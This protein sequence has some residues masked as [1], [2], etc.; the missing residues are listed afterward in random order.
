MEE[1]HSQAS[2]I[3]FGKI[4]GVQARIAEAMDAA[5]RYLFSRQDPEE[6]HWCGELEADSTLESD[7]IVLHTLLG[8]G[9]AVKMEKATREILRHQNED[10][11]WSIFTDGPSNVSAT[12]KAYFSLK[13]MGHK[14]D[15]PLLVKGPEGILANGG[16]PARN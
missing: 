3:R 12:V 7:Y 5:K 9:D 14:P 6:G 16:A 2:E 4:D 13:L 15:E 10:G 8:K 1:K 11:G